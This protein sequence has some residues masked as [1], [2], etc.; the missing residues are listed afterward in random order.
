MYNKQLGLFIGKIR[1]EKNIS[2]KSLAE[3]ICTQS[4]LSSIENGEKDAS[5]LMLDFLLQRL[6]VSEDGYE[7]YLSRSKY[8]SIMQRYTILGLIENKETLKSRKALD[9][10][11]KD[12]GNENKFHMQFILHIESRLLIL[13]GNDCKSAYEKVRQAV[14]LTVPRIEKTKLS[15][16]VV[17][18]NELFLIIEYFRL[19]SQVFNNISIDK[20]YEELIEYI[21]NSKCEDLIKAKLYPKVVCLVCKYWIYQNEYEKMLFHCNKSI[22]YLQSSGKLYFISDIL[23]N[24]SLALKNIINHNKYKTEEKS[25]KLIE[26]ENE[27]KITIEW[28]NIIDELFL[29]YNVTNEPYEWYPYYSSKEIYFIGD[30]IRRR[31]N[32]L[33]MSQEEL[34]NGI[35]SAVTL[36][37]IE[38]GS[39]SPH[40]KIARNLLK[41]LNLSGI[42]YS[43]GI[44]SDD[45]ETHKMCDKLDDYII[46]RKYDEAK[47]LLETISTKLDISDPINK[48]YFMY[49][50]ILI[51]KNLDMV[52]Q[53]DTLKKFKEALLVTLPRYIF[54]KDTCSYYTKIEIM[55][56]IN[57]AIILEKLGNIAEALKLYESIEFYYNNIINDISNHII[58]YE[59]FIAN[60]ES[61]LGNIG[62][63]EKSND[64][65]EKII[66]ENL[67][68][69]RGSF[70]VNFLYSKAWNTKSSVEQKREMQPW[71]KD[72]YIKELKKSYIISCI[73]NNK[74]LGEFIKSKI[75]CM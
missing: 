15:N 70:I 21:E 16:L 31:R 8:K 29:E 47:K 19:K 24:K 56:M 41:K 1:T 23:K 65:I 9:L 68:S 14:L 28:K 50:Q 40:P 58:I 27:Y 75:K 43:A 38:N 64:L 39:T 2:V 32:M 49:K 12:Y 60:Y 74:T 46:L 36:S 7:S 72:L 67:K 25:Y 54:F 10:Y 37:R 35:C 17:G 55:I 22:E 33:N 63:Y 59:L 51:F 11:I 30:V 18:F 3:G 48:Q 34:S 61:I 20:E 53:E 42:L 66:V 71:D 26:F 69:R 62:M 73:M 52:S 13:E 6:G 57:I 44:I 5:K 4:F 45:Y